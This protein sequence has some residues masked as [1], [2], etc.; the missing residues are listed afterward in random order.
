MDKVKY[1]DRLLKK[2]A[3]VNL[4]CNSL[5]IDFQDWYLWIDPDF[6]L[7]KGKN[8]QIMTTALDCPNQAL[9]NYSTLFKDWCALFESMNDCILSDYEMLNSGLKISFNNDQSIFIPND[10]KWNDNDL[11]YN[12]WYVEKSDHSFHSNKKEQ[13]LK[14]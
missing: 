2:S 13:G 3:K 5:K 1:L 10:E 8:D 4:V 9:K 14:K 11:W 6:Y 7:T 12:H